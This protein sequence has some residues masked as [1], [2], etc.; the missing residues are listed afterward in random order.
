[1]SKRNDIARQICDSEAF[2]WLMVGS[3]HQEAHLA[4]LRE[5]WRAYTA[6]GGGWGKRVNPDNCSCLPYHA[7][8][9]G[10][11]PDCEVHGMLDGDGVVGPPNPQCNCEERQ[12]KWDRGE[13]APACPIHGVAL[14]LNGSLWPVTF[15]DTMDEEP[16]GDDVVGPPKPEC[17]CDLVHALWAANTL[18]PACPIHGAMG[19]SND[20]DAAYD[21]DILD[22]EAARPQPK[23]V[24]YDRQR[25]HKNDVSYWRDVCMQCGCEVGDI[26]Q[27]DLWHTKTRSIT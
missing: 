16:E 11:E 13:T 5:G 4:A 12:A 7:G 9:D 22:R 1:M 21:K 19:Y 8:G 10:P 2:M 6:M 20:E 23:F 17:N 14:V 27:H 15:D 25:I 18:S 3:N 26:D 24:S